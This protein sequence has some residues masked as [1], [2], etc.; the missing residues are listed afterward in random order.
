MKGDVGQSDQRDQKRTFK[1]RQFFP[2]TISRMITA[3]ST[4]TYVASM[5]AAAQASDLICHQHGGPSGKPD[6]NQRKKRTALQRH[7]AGPVWNR[8]QEKASHH[9]RDISKQQFM[10]VPGDR[11]ITFG[12]APALPDSNP[13]HSTMATQAHAPAPRK[14]GRKP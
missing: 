2:A 1:L 13:T 10:G 6:E 11:A 4:N 14:N 7:P 5:T 9:R 3:A 8:G 12:E